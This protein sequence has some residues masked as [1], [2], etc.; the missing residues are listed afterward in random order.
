MGKVQ[1]MAGLLLL[2]TAIGN[3]LAPTEAQAL[4]R[5]SARY[6]QTCALCHIDPTGGG[7]RS[8]YAVQELI[9]KELAWPSAKSENPIGLN[10]RIGKNLLVGADVREVY[11]TSDHPA[12]RLDFFQMQG[13]VYLSFVPDKHFTLYMDRGQSGAY[14]VFGLAYLFPWSGYLKAGRFTPSHGWKFED[15]TMF[16]RSEEGFSPPAQTDVGLELGATP[17]PFDIQVDLVNGNRGST[18]GADNHLAAGVNALGRFSVA[19][20]SVAIGAA[21]Y[22]Q[23]GRFQDLKTGGAFGS[24]NLGRFTWVGEGD[25][26]RTEPAVGTAVTGLAT[27]HQLDITLHQGLEVKGTFDFYDPD[28]DLKSG[29]KRRWGGGVC[30]MPRPYAVLEADYR[31]TSVDPGSAIG[32]DGFTET[33]AQL[34]FLY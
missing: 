27:S 33:I 28:V 16:V 3:G 30:L 12:D 22:R 17:G 31:V 1:R 29:S 32:G 25:L 14:E 9:P 5:Y 11:V 7:Q 24:L 13:D 6:G 26:I 15:H 8:E 10:P 19:G 34:H 20:A 23:P 18:M 2:A 4:P 21:G